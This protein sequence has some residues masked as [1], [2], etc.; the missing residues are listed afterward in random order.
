MSLTYDKTA[1][2]TKALEYCKN[3]EI[4]LVQQLGFGT[5][6]VVFL[7]S[8][9][10]AIKVYNLKEGYFRERDVYRRLKDRNIDSIQNL[11]IPR[12]VSWDDRLTLFE[13]SVVHVPC[14]LDFGGAYLDNPP[15]HM[16]RD[17]TWIASKSEEFGENWEK[18][19]A[20]IREIEHRADIWLS[21]INTGNIKFEET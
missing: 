2:K 12:I 13:M 18:A 10:T 21:D 1:L 20:V 11:M 5:Q 6:G 14:I 16:D 8:R 15:E 9:N 7:T 4:Q 19:Q 17:E 3:N